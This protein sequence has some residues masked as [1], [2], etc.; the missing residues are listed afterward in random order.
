MGVAAP[1]CTPMQT[2]SSSVSGSEMP[3]TAHHLYKPVSWCG[4]GDVVAEIGL[5]AQ[6]KHRPTRDT[7]AFFDTPNT[8]QEF[9]PKHVQRDKRQE[10]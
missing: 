2:G 6:Y 7:K 3:D 9:Q 5:G 4:F 8:R 10:M 1:A